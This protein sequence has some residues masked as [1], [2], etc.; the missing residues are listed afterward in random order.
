MHLEQEDNKTETHLI[1][2]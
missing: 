1:H 2:R